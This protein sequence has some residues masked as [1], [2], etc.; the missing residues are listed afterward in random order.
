MGVGFAAFVA[1][2][3]IS[4][5][6]SPAPSRSGSY[7]TLREGENLYRVSLRFGVPVAEIAK[8]NRISDVRRV[9]AG[10]RLWIPSAPGRIPPPP[11]IS[12]PA[13]EFAWPVQGWVISGFGQRSGR[14]HEGIDVPARPGTP[15]KASA[16]GSV[17]FA[18]RLGD[19]GNTVV[20]D[21]G[22][23]LRSVYA[24]ASSIRVRPGQRVS[25]GEPIATVGSTGR[26]T[27]PHLHFEIRRAGEPTDPISYLR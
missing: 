2:G 1:L 17:V 21:H 3:S 19:Y 22:F 24:H 20:I 8:Q 15:I 16:P 18:G 7:Y 10:M 12:G 4:G 9:P 25:R 5:C 13:P 11:R 27:G 14:M 26:A 23:D 6:A